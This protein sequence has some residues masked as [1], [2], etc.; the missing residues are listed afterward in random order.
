M[1]VMLAT[2]AN[3]LMI[4]REAMVLR[5]RGADSRAGND[6]WPI[7]G[8]VV[9]DQDLTRTRQGRDLL[10]HL[11]AGF[12]VTLLDGMC[13]LSVLSDDG[14]V[15][16]MTVSART[17]L[18]LSVGIVLPAR[19]LRAELGMLAQGPTIGITTVGLARRLRAGVDTKTALGLFALARSSPLACL[20]ALAA[21]S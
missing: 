11:D 10:A 19:S 5:P 21:A 16:R 1:A 13:G 2:T 7:F 12:G 9:D 14:P 18:P 4:A 15:L 20:V 17:P 8:L 6:L 3:Q